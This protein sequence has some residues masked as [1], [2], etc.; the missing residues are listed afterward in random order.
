VAPGTSVAGLLHAL[1][2]AGARTTIAAMW[3]IP[4]E[5]TTRFMEAFYAGVL[6]GAGCAEALRTAQRQ[7]A[8]RGE[9]PATWAA[10][11]GYGDPNPIAYRPGARL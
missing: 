4:D 5:A 1:H 9:P 3:P 2:R 7:Q 10:Y 8:A 11:V 6:G